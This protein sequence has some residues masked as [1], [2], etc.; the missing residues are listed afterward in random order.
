MAADHK[1]IAQ[2]MRNVP[3]RHPFRFIDEILELDDEHIVGA[4]R[5]REDEFFYQ[6]HFPDRP[7]TPGVILVETMAQTGLVA[8][9]LYLNA[10][11]IQSLG[12][13]FQNQTFFTLAD[14][15][16]FLGAVEPGERVIIRG[17]KV[18]FRLGNLKVRVS[19]ERE[20]GGMIS[21]ALLGGLRVSEIWGCRTSYFRNEHDDVGTQ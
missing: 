5:F 1:T 13:T 9:E 14:E 7:I 3:H 8:F 4:Y 12:D 21:T 18:Y 15:I 20:N 17:H 16:E 19:M 10:Q 11:N 6:G 2:I